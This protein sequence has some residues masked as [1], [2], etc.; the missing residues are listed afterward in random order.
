MQE[1]DGRIRVMAQLIDAIGGE[2]L[3]AERFDR[4]LTELFSIQ[5]EIAHKIAVSLQVKLTEGKDADI[6]GGTKNIKAWELLRKG[7]AIHQ[8]FT[9]EGYLKARELYRRALEI[10]PH[11]ANAWATMA[12]T[13]YLEYTWVSK[14]QELMRLSV[15]YME[16]ALE[17]D[18]TEPWALSLS[19]YIYFDQGH[20]E[21]AIVQCR[22]NVALYPSSA[23]NNY[24]LA[25]LLRR[26]GMPNE[27]LP[28]IK[29]AIRLNPFH[30]LYY[31]SLLAD[32]YRYLQ[33]YDKAIE[34]CEHLLERAQRDND[35]T[36]IK[37]AHLIIASSLAGL[38]NLKKAQIHI[39]ERRRLNPP[40]SLESIRRYAIW[41]W[42]DE[43]YVKRLIELFQ[44]AGLQ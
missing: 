2:H 43:A 22:K 5:D 19:G 33:K 37:Q 12:W 14:D 35:N 16:K 4:E 24:N 29:K 13:Y 9:P 42:K 18:A 1:S 41:F 32:L 6:R 17:I 23:E 7:W 34:V 27:A 40:T 26:T 36:H 20:Y 25:H 30:P 3:W 28:I 15:E 38:G 11:Y 31:D 8:Q 39:D 44:T 10:D 21:K